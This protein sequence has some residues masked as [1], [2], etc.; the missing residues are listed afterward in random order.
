MFFGVLNTR[1]DVECQEELGF[2]ML[3]GTPWVSRM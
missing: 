3:L 2:K 1:A